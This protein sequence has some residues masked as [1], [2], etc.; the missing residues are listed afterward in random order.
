MIEFFEVR[1]S[2]AYR[3]ARHYDIIQ[4][5]EVT[6]RLLDLGAQCILDDCPCTRCADLRQIVHIAPP[7]HAT[8]AVDLLKELIAGVN[9]LE[10]TGG[11]ELWADCDGYEWLARAEA[12]VGS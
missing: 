4:L 12:L 5:A 8:S 9:Q 2:G 3:G 10:G 6:N 11:F 7:E 1:P